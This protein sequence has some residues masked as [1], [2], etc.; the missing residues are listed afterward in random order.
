VKAAL[1]RDGVER[2]RQDAESALI[3][4]D[5]PWRPAALLLVGVASGLDGHDEAADDAL[6]DAQELAEMWGQADVALAAVSERALLAVEHDDWSAAESLLDTASAIRS[7][8]QLG[9]YTVSAL[10]HALSARAALRHRDLPRANRELILATRLRPQLTRAVPWFAVQSLIELARAHI[11]LADTGGARMVIQ[12]IDA[13][14]RRRP[15]LGT[16]PEKANELRSQVDVLRTQRLQ[17]TAITAAELRVLP[18]LTT[19]LTFAE[20]GKHLYV[21]PHTVKT[22]AV[23]I[24]RKLGVTS[25]AAAI[26]RARDI[27]I[28]ES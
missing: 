4:P 23:S 6:S 11:A 8:F 14:L 26:D 25:R 1:C 19:H 13:V 9:R 27:G 28:I 10:A 16:L 17:V 22:Q 3:D 21:S 18:Y 7:R 24:Y 5:G 12:E 2:M 15:G 20:I